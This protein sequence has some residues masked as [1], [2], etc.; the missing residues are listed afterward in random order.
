MAF[1]PEFPQEYE[2]KYFPGGH[3]LRDEANAIVAKAFR[4]GPLEDLH[5]GKDS[6]LVEDDRYSR[7]TDEEMKQLMLNACEQVEKLL[8][9]K[10]DSPR[11]YELEIKSYGARYCSRWE[12]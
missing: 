11:E 12:R 3:T 1:I 8:R 10:Q 7:I 5:A 9:L 2:E 4:N 6:E